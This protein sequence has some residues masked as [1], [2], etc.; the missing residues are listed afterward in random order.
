MV[1]I[2]FSIGR[3]PAAVHR[4]GINVVKVFGGLQY[5]GKETVLNGASYDI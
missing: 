1:G 3:T 2:Q 4:S 5:V